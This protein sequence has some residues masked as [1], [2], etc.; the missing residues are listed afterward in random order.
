MTIN[1]CKY[2][3]KNNIKQNKKSKK[4]EVKEGIFFDNFDG[5]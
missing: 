4:V 3:N 1:V 5:D 2:H